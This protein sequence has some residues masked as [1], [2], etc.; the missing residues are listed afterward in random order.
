M[1]TLLLALSLVV[2]SAT[3]SMAGPQNSP[4]LCNEA[5]AQQLVDSQICS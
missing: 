2:M 5:D 3:S 1:K 4:Y